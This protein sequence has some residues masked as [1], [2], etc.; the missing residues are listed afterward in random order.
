MQNIVFFYKFGFPCNSSRSDAL[1]TS[2]WVCMHSVASDIG[3]FLAMWSPMPLLYPLCFIV[4]V[5]RRL[6][7]WIWNPVQNHTLARVPNLELISHEKRK[8]I[9]Y[10]SNVCCQASTVSH[11]RQGKGGIWM[12]RKPKPES[13]LEVQLNAAIKFS[14]G[15]PLEKLLMVVPYV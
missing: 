13:G 3:M 14:I 5:L 4:F 6:R 8:P 11:Y 15:S 1:G 12:Q 7:C 2:K 9:S 10:K